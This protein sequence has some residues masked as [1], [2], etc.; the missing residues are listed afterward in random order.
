MAF[1]SVSVKPSG[2][3]PSSASVGGFTSGFGAAFISCPVA[4]S[5]SLATKGSAGPATSSGGGLVGGSGP[6]PSACL[7]A[8]N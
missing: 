7:L 1:L 5:I 8:D 4:G 6:P 3:I 2:P